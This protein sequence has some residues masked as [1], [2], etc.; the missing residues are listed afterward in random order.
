MTIRASRS[1]CCDLPAEDRDL[2]LRIGMASGRAWAVGLNLQDD[3]SRSSARYRD[4]DARDVWRS[5]CPDGGISLATLFF[6]AAKHGYVHSRSGKAGRAVTAPASRRSPPG[7]KQSPI[8]TATVQRRCAKA[9]RRA[10]SCRKPSCVPATCAE[11]HYLWWPGAAV[12]CRPMAT[13]LR[14]ASGAAWT[15]TAIAIGASPGAKGASDSM[16]CGGSSPEYVVLVEGV[17]LP[18]ALVPRRSRHWA[19]PEPATGR[20]KP[21]CGGAHRRRADLCRRRTRRRRAGGAALDRALRDSRS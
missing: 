12:H 6:E 9:T 16:G 8:N 5:I 1:R 10:N 14:C 11:I 18:H 13:R 15:R 19:F 3:W 7:R 21:G 4:T 17:R 20:M 2:W